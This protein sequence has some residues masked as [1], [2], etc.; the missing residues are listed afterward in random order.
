VLP[1]GRGGR[2]A[3]AA[4]AGGTAT[5]RSPAAV[6]FSFTI[7]VS[8]S[9]RT[10]ARDDVQHSRHG[11]S[12]GVAEDVDVRCVAARRTSERTTRTAPPRWPARSGSAVR[13]SARRPAGV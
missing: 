8:G 9:G 5:S 11:F 6:L 12:V 2:G 7:G 3:W 13:G 1:T 4:G 10:T